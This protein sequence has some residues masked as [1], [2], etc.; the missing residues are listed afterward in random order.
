MKCNATHSK[1]A[2]LKL[3]KTF[4]SLF[5]N[6]CKLRLLVSIVFN[7]QD[8]KTLHNT[9][10]H[11]EVHLPS[12]S[13]PPCQ[14]PGPCSWCRLACSAPTKSPETKHTQWQK[15]ELLPDYKH[16]FFARFLVA[17]AWWWPLF[18]FPHFTVGA[19]G[20]WPGGLCGFSLEKGVYWIYE[21]CWKFC[22]ERER[23]GH[24]WD[25]TQ[26]KH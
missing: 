7:T 17:R 2:L 22:P 20:S 5:W 13:F 16:W 11:C 21:N 6:V 8:W 24:G 25:I 19:W 4:R 23:R 10:L 3:F 1:A 18:I 9:W 15:S 26:L 12:H 14:R